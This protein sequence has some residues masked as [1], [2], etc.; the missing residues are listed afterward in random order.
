MNKGL[1]ISRSRVG[2]FSKSFMNVLSTKRS[3]PFHR[4]GKLHSSVP[5]TMWCKQ[6]KG[7]R[8]LWNYSNP[9]RALGSFMNLSAAAMTAYKQHSYS[10]ITQSITLDDWNG[11]QQS[12]TE[13]P[14]VQ[15]N[16]HVSL[17][18]D[19]NIIAIIEGTGKICQAQDICSLLRGAIGSK[20]KANSNASRRPKEKI[21]TAATI[22]KQWD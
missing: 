6:N 12:N 14:P 3:K 22:L 17:F 5:N 21:R 4:K 20:S 18:K 13:L 15:C 2:K 19:F 11:H 1:L 8:F 7:I 10:A 9:N 16:N